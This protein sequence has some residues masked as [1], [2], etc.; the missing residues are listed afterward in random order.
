VTT[1]GD[2]SYGLS[3][4][5]K[6][7]F[8]TVDGL[9]TLFTYDSFAGSNPVNL[10]YMECEGAV[11]ESGTFVLR[12]EDTS[13][14]ITEDLHN[15]KVY[16][17]LGKSEA[18]LQYFMIG[19]ADIHRT[20]RPVTNYKQFIITGFGSAIQAGRLFIHRR[21]ASKI[22]NPTVSPDGDFNINKLAKRAIENRSWRPLKDESIKDITGWLTTGIS[23]KVNINF[24]VVN[25]PFTYLSDFLDQLCAVSG[26]VWFLDFS[27]GT[28]KFTLTY[29]TDLHTGVTIK[30][31]DLQNRLA[32]NANTTS[33]IKTEFGVEDSS[34]GETGFATRLYTS[35]IIDQNTVA[36]SFVN[37][38]STNTT[39]KAIAQQVIIDSDARRIDSIAMILS[40]VGDPSSPKD[41]LNGEIRLDNGNNSPRDGTILDKFH[42]DLSQIESSPRTIFVNDINVKERLLEGGQKKIWILIGQRSN[43]ED[44][45]GDPDGNGNPNHGNNHT[46]R[47][48]HNGLFNQSPALSLYSGTAESGDLDEDDLDWKNT[49]KGPT[50]TYSIFSDIR[51]MQ[52]RTNKQAAANFGLREVFLPTD[53]IQSSKLVTQ[54]MSLNLSEMS[55][56][57]RSL[58]GFR[59]TLPN[60]FIFKPYQ[61][62][63]FSDGLSGINQDFQVK[64]VSYIIDSTSGNPQIGTLHADITLGGLYNRLLADCSCS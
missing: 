61:W 28:E 17:Q 55:K 1:T 25:A 23:D 62:V 57:R 6:I 60:N 59:V 42:I 19:F 8:K 30:S 10:T 20:D 31:G 45:N 26:A 36:S 52:A 7:T 21:E 14:A 44:E 49:N 29:N 34:M 53:F 54:F 22:D 40:K 24:P 33:Y 12:I 43:E 46:I 64:R 48:H 56:P 18:T 38:G 41:R 51:K 11:G 39:F 27:E 47:W 3:V 58:P 37:A 32:D 16:I 15:C 13:D 50:Y 4:R 9:T 2:F 5:A 35:T 63:S